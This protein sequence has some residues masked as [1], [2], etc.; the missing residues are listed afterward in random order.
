MSPVTGFILSLALTLVLLGLAV[1][2]GFAGRRR[3]HVSVVA[4]ALASLVV[5]IY[6]ATELGELY[7][8]DSAGVITPIHLALAKLAAVS[9]LLPV[10]TGL[11]TWKNARF[12]P[13]HRK[14]AFLALGLTVLAAVTGTAMVLLSDRLP[15]Q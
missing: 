13:L 15:L 2:T 12:K 7:D 1:A 10:Y 5:T 3:I 8:L 4:S 6:Y 14:L 11:R 9:F